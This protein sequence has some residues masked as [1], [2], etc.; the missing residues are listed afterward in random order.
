MEPTDGSGQG[1]KEDNGAHTN[2]NKESKVNNRHVPATGRGGGVRTGRIE[3]G[4]TMTERVEGVTTN[5]NE[6]TMGDET[7]RD[8][9]EEMDSVVVKVPGTKRVVMGSDATR[10]AAAEYKSIVESIMTWEMVVE[11]HEENLKNAT[12]EEDR[13]RYRQTIASSKKLLS[14]FRREEHDHFLSGSYKNHE[15]LLWDE[16]D[17]EEEDEDEPVEVVGVIQSN[18]A[19]KFSNMQNMELEAEGFSEDEDVEMGDKDVSLQ[20]GKRKDREDILDD[21]K[22]PSEE[23][24]TWKVVTN[25]KKSQ[26]KTKTL[27]ANRNDRDEEEQQ[28]KSDKQQAELHRGDIENKQNSSI[29][30]NQP[31]SKSQLS[32]K[33]KNAEQNKRTSL[34]KQDISNKNKGNKT[35]VITEEPRTRGNERNKKETNTAELAQQND[36]QQTGYGARSSLQRTITSYASA[37]KITQN[38]N[39]IRFNFS[40]NVRV[41]SPSEWRRVAKILLEQSYEVDNKAV[42]LPWDDT[43][44]ENGQGMT[45][46]MVSNKLTMRDSL[47]AKYFNAR[48]NMIPGKIYYQAGVRISTELQTNIFIDKWNGN[49]RDRKERGLEVLNIGLANMQNS[50]DSYLIG[51]AVG[52]SEDQDTTILNKKLE[53]ATGI[54]GI[55]VSYQNFYQAGITNEFWD[56]ANKKAKATGAHDMSREFLRCKYGWAPSALCVYVPKIYMVA[57]ARQ[58]MIQKYGKLIEGA[59]PQ[60]PDGTRM[61]FLPI[62]GGNLKSEK[63]KAI[64]KKRIAYHIWIKAHER[65]ITTN[66]INIHEGQEIFEGKS[67]SQLILQMESMY[68]DNLALFR[69]FKRTWSNGQDNMGRWALSVHK[70]LYEEALTKL[71]GLQQELLNKYGDKVN[72]FFADQPARAFRKDESTQIGEDDEDNWFDDDDSIPEKAVI[73]QGFEK[74]LDDDQSEVSWGTNLTK[75]T[76]L[77]QPSTLSTITSSITQEVLQVDPEELGRRQAAVEHYLV[78]QYGMDKDTILK[79]KNHEAPYRIVTRAIQDKVWVIDEVLE[80]INAIFKAQQIPKAPDP[81]NNDDNDDDL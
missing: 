79:V 42:I 77:V 44:V 37:T 46:E 34:I 66:L 80:G 62:K 31:M 38:S 69:H 29:S 74:F 58:S 25:K 11:K 18:H 35:V 75:Y 41:N 28:N 33:N 55:E 52:S 7:K 71:Q 4:E 61:R 21:A 81:T 59:N 8:S 47:I 76:E 54:K 60:W 24:G 9:D 19:T 56:I 2:F 70:G 30:I 20:S 64:I 22:L 39:Q 53:E 51:I 40:F 6:T 14:Q 67:L 23:M 63:T 45:L 36:K 57:K 5:D 72:I 12:N 26:A 32:S 73:E 49:K 10:K 68:T 48:G 13:E 17:K 78:T 16:S 1:N 50:V 27:K 43:K 15:V 65:T 3:T